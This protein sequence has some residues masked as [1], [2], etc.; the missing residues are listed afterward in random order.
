MNA[1]GR[2][3][4]DAIKAAFSTQEKV[5]DF[6]YSP[7]NIDNNKVLTDMERIYVTDKFAYTGKMFVNGETYPGQMCL[8]V[9]NELGKSLSIKQGKENFNVSLTDEIQTYLDLMNEFKK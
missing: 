3:I 9:Y 1:T 7:S 5:I 2:N 6:W 8:E 4:E